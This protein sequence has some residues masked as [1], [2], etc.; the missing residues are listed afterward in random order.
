MTGLDAVMQD[1]VRFKFLITP[2]TEQQLGQVIV[3]DALKP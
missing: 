1:G 2:L 3:I